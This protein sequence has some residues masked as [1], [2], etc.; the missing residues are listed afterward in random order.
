MARTPRPP[1]GTAQLPTP[2]QGPIVQG[3]EGHVPPSLPDPAHHRPRRL[4]GP[5]EN[6][7]ATAAAASFPQTAPPTDHSRAHGVRQPRP[8]TGEPARGC[9]PWPVESCRAAGDQRAWGRPGA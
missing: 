8:G 9:R 6:G 1:P 5:P 3:L 4:A 7:G 2:T